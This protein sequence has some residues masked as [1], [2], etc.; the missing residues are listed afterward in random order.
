MINRPHVIVQSGRDGLK[1]CAPT[2]AAVC[3]YRK[4]GEAGCRVRDGRSSRLVLQANDV[5]H[6]P[7]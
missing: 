7:A 3:V 4:R 6:E 2:I 1:A 5:R